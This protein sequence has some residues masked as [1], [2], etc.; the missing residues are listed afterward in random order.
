LLFNL[1]LDV[2]KLYLDNISVKRPLIYYNFKEVI[3]GIWY[4]ILK[5]IYN[6]NAVLERVK[7]VKATIGLK[8]K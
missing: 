8:F 5:Y 3:L 6:L 7:R 2:Y 1:I 4:F